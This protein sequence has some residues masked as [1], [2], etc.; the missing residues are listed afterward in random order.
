MKV[1]RT[2]L[3]TSR[4]SDP[5]AEFNSPQRVAWRLDGLETDSPTP[6]FLGGG[7]AHMSNFL[8]THLAL[9][10]S[11]L[12]EHHIPSSTAFARPQFPGNWSAS[13]AAGVSAR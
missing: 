7:Y 3:K 5:S 13:T 12:P 10:F 6:A 9:S 4:G 8:S 2:V 1:S 11:R